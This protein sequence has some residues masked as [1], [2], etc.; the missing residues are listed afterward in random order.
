[1]LVIGS[2]LLAFYVFA[3]TTLS[4]LVGLPLVP[5]LLV[6]ILVVPA[7]QDKLGKWLALRGA[8]D[9]PDDQRFGHDHQMVRRFCRDMGIEEPRLIVIWIWAC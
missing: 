2:I 5:V 8:E 1:M 4:V 9:M 7:I 3:G 6:G